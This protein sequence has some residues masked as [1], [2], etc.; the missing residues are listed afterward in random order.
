MRLSTFVRTIILTMLVFVAAPLSVGSTQTGHTQ[1]TNPEGRGGELIFGL[2]S[3]PPTMDPHTSGSA[4]TP[5]VGNAIFDTLVWQAPDLSFQPYLATSWEVSADGMNWTFTLQQGV[6]FH[7]GTPFNAEA[8]K[9]NLDRVVNPE[10][11]AGS[12]IALLGPYTGSQVV[13]EYTIQ[14]TFA[15]PFAPLLSGLS[16]SLLGMVSPTAAAE[17]GPDFG[18]APVGTGAFIFKEWVRRDHIT[19]E[20]NPD[21]NWAP[22]GQGHQGPA[23]LE[24]VIFKFIPEDATRIAT[25]ET[26]ETNAIENVPAQDLPRLEENDQVQIY[27]VPIPGA[28]WH[29]NLNTSKAPLDDPLVRQALIY[30]TNTQAI[31]DTLFAGIHTPANGPLN[32]VTFGY[33]GNVESLYEYDLERARAL[34][35]EAGWTMGP[36][37]IRQKNGQPLVLSLYVIAAGGYD[38]TA[39][40][41]QGQLREAGVEVEIVLQERATMFAN[42]NKGD[43]HMGLRF[44][45]GSDPDILDLHFHS[46]DQGGWN[47]SKYKNPRIDGL[48]EQGAQ[49]LNNDERQAIYAEIQGIL[50]ADAVMIPLFDHKYVVAANSQVKDLKFDVRT[51]IWL[52]DTYIED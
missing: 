23:Y 43:H 26:G 41:V 30:A 50:M 35:E 2:A 10:T 36:D 40:M 48:L 20:R 28:P 33:S 11:Q 29:I 49:T 12:A 47:W 4:W 46:S 8:V 42:V 9:Y 44:W 37:D 3:E 38:E 22:A 51:W 14:V 21:Y 25:L 17:A 45:Y 19:V 39:Q 6:T 24:Q 34:L 15:A 13:D 31:V 5:R 16:Q 32:A 1:Q 52:Y 18:V 27:A 7:D